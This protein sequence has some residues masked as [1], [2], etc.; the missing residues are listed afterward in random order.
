MCELMIEKGVVIDDVDAV[1]E[2]IWNLSGKTVS[3]A[4]TI[5]KFVKNEKSTR[6]YV[7]NKGSCKMQPDADTVYLWLDSGFTDYCGDPIMISLLNSDGGYRGH[8]AGS[9]NTLANKIRDYYP[10]NIRHINNN[11]D[12]FKS[13][14]ERKI[15]E[16]K[17]KH[18]DDEREYLISLSN[19]EACFGS[20]QYVLNGIKIDIS[21][22][23]AEEP[24][25]VEEEIVKTEEPE[26]EMT[27]DEQEITIGLLLEKIDDMQEYIDELLDEI[28]RFNS[29]DKVKMEELEAK[30]REYRKALVDMRLFMEKEEAGRPE[31]NEKD[32]AEGHSLLG[33]NSKILVLGAT[34]LDQKTMNGIAKTYGFE[35]NDFEYETDYSKIVSFASRINS[36]SRYA[37]IIIGA[38]PHKV[39]NLGDWSSLIEKCKNDENLPFACDARSKAG[40]LKVTK[41][42]YRNALLSVC[43]ELKMKKAG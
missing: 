20:M 29:E 6:F 37:A 27:D 43:N 19:E 4:E 36:G 26:Y 13:K 30:N 21:L 9:F 12:S 41:E 15:S 33:R 2:W 32:L 25:T 8:F 14:Y 7:D 5:R 40:E 23:E 35:K 11:L 22:P 1:M 38:C 18:I 10:Q 16:R 42:S 31:D 17:T 34:A 28:R 3:G 39:Q 24:E